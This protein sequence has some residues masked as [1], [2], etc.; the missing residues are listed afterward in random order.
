MTVLLISH[1]SHAV[2]WECK[3]PFV[4]DRTFGD[5]GPLGRK[6]GRAARHCVDELTA[7]SLCSAARC[8]VGVGVCEC[9]V[10]RLGI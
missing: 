7:K 3:P 6:L 8:R 10:K 1:S 2:G 5:R 4:C 9:P